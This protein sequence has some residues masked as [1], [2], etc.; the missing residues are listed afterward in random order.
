MKELPFDEIEK[1]YESIAMQMNIQ[2][3][4][5]FAYLQYHLLAVA[6]F[7]TDEMPEGISETGEDALRFVLRYRTSLMLG[8]P[9]SEFESLW[10][11]ARRTFPHWV[12]FSTDRCEP[13]EQLKSRYLR[14]RRRSM[15]K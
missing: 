14:L 15:R 4:S 1:E 6:L 2:R 11:A 9:Q 3:R 10:T 12:G 7:W 5:R 8:N 13:S